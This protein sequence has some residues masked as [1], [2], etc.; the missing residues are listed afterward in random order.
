[1]ELANVHDRACCK[2]DRQ[3]PIQNCRTQSSQSDRNDR[4][5]YEYLPESVTES[6]QTPQHRPCRSVCSSKSESEYPCPSKCRIT[7]R[8]DEK[9]PPAQCFNQPI[10][11]KGEPCSY[12]FEW[13]RNKYVRDGCGSGIVPNVKTKDTWC[14][15]PLSMYQAT[16]GE[17]GR[18]MLCGESHM[19]RDLNTAPPCSMCQYVLPPCRGYYRKRD[20]LRP[21]E[22]DYVGHSGGQKTYRDPVE[23]YWQPCMTEEEKSASIRNYAAHNAYLGEM[24]RRRF[25]NTT[26]CW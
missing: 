15:T 4:R 19:V 13:Q 1:M 11:F 24:I 6:Q 3:E 26:P 9:L 14:K 5:K 21:C 10:R 22:E 25:D 7:A 20:C 12:E 18:K 17:L 8:S 23:R 16:I 2:K